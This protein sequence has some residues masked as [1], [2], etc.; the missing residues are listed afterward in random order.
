ME[1]RIAIIGIFV[2]D[3]SQAGAINDILHEYSEHII[4][5]MGLPYKQ[6]NIGVISIIVDAPNNIV[7]A[8]SGKIGALK[9][10][11]CKTM[12]AKEQGK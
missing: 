5:R 2:E 1:N 3:M 6:K 8:L 12:H 4:G 9:D 7:S 11:H 10:V